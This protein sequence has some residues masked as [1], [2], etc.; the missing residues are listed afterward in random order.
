VAEDDSSRGRDL[1]SRALA[2]AALSAVVLVGCAAKAHAPPS[3][4]AAAPASTEEDRALRAETEE[5]RAAQKVWC[6][7]LQALYVR[8]TGATAPWPRFS[9]CAAATTTAAPEMLRRTAD[10]SKRALDGFRGDP[11]TPEYALLVG[12][13]GNEAIDSLA[14]SERDVA[15]Y[16]AAI[17]S[18]A[19]VC[20]GVDVDDCRDRIGAGL[21][22]HL[23]R[24]VGAMNRKGRARLRACLRTAACSD[25]GS[26]VSSCL[27]PIMEDLLWLP[28]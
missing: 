24:A 6:N 19:N 25:L 10:C 2:P 5:Q 1:R 3:A 15:P 21:G 27:E 7:Y 17:C 8:S 16:V 9:Q 28:G 12:R 23:E 13:C 14:A 11:F 18:R 26:Q 4:P 22:P 20:G